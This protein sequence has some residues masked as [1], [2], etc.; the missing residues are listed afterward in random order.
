MSDSTDSEA[1]TYTTPVASKNHKPGSGIRDA[2]RKGLSKVQNATSL[3]K[4]SRAAI[5]GMKSGKVCVRLVCIPHTND[6]V[7]DPAI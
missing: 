4:A 6:Y 7:L 5:E 2:I 1:E 3:E